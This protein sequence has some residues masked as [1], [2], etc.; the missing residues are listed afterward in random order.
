MAGSCDINT[1]AKLE[2]IFEAYF[3]SKPITVK[4][5]APFLI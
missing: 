3:L 4:T 5:I 1:I 2:D